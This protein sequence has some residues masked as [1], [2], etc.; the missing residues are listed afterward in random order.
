MGQTFG[1]PSREAIESHYHFTKEEKLVDLAVTVSE[2][3]QV[4]VRVQSV[5]QTCVQE[6]DG[7]LGGNT[8]PGGLTR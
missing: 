6:M 2:E 8:G 3:G 5:D 4:G 7:E 1:L